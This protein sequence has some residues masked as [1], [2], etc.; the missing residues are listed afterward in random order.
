MES[1]GCLRDHHVVGGSVGCHLTAP[2]PNPPGSPPTLMY[3]YKERK[4][5]LQ[6]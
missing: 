1:R 3:G 6:V 4:I 5:C 2:S